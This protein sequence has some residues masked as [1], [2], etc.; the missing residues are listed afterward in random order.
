MWLAPL[1]TRIL[2]NTFTSPVSSPTLEQQLYFLTTLCQPSLPLLWSQ[3]SLRSGALFLRPVRAGPLLSIPMHLKRW[4]QV[5][6]SA[7]AKH[8]SHLLSHPPSGP[9]GFWHGPLIALYCYHVSMGLFLPHQKFPLALNSSC[10]P[11]EALSRGY[12]IHFSPLAGRSLCHLI[13]LLC[14]STKVPPYWPW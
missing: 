8:S 12:L 9:W 6:I 10:T 1:H 14:L 13:D 7:A 11:L 2:A 3:L 4:G 5:L